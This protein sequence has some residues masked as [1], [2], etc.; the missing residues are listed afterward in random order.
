MIRLTKVDPFSGEEQGSVWFAWDAVGTVEPDWA[1]KSPERGTIVYRKG[2]G[3]TDAARVRENPERV[4][5]L[6]EIEKAAARAPVAMQAARDEVWL[7]VYLAALRMYARPPDFTAQEVNLA[8]LVAECARDAFDGH[9]VKLTT[10]VT[11]VEG[12]RP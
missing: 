10:T 7:R 12:S 3:F 8:T 1:S 4:L 11:N 2:S 6:I 9:E 5:E